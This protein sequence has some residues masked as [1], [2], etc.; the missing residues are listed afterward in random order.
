MNLDREWEKFKG[1]PTIAS[2]KRF[3]VTMNANGAIFLNSNTHK[4]LG[5]PAG[6]AL[7]YHRDKDTIAIEPANVRLA[8]SFPVNQRSS[9]WMVYASPFCRHF[10]IKLSTTESFI[11]P[12]VNDQGALLLN[13]RT[14]VTV[15]GPIRK[16]P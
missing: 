1:G 12:D 2:Q 10:R 8:E 3:Y 5:S 14:T 15:S 4:A 9:G 7:Y 16:R 13:L 11:N 6:V